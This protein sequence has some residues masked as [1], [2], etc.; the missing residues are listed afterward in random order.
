MQMIC[1]IEDNIKKAATAYLKAFGLKEGDFLTLEAF[2]TVEQSFNEYENDT[3]S[4]YELQTDGV[5][6]KIT[7]PDIVL[8]SYQQQTGN[9]PYVQAN[10]SNYDGLLLANVKD[11]FD[12]Q[13]ETFKRFL[14][15]GLLSVQ[16]ILKIND[17]KIPAGLKTEFIQLRQGILDSRESG[18]FDRAYLAFGQYLLEGDKL[19]TTAL[20]KINEIRSANL[21]DQDRF[22]AINQLVD[23]IAPYRSIVGELFS[24]LEGAPDNMLKNLVTALKTT[25]ATIDAIH[26]KEAEKY[27]IIQ[28]DK[29]LTPSR[30]EYERQFH[31]EIAELQAHAGASTGRIRETL[32]SKI[33]QK[34]DEFRDSN[35]TRG[36]I[37]KVLKGEFGDSSFASKWVGAAITNGDVIVQGFNLALKQAMEGIYNQTNSLRSEFAK[38]YDDF[39]RATGITDFNGQDF[40]KKY[41]REVDV[42][43]YDPK[44]NEVLS[45]KTY[46]ILH[47]HSNERFGVISR[48]KAELEMAEANKNKPEVERLTKLYD[49]Y[50]M[51]N[52]ERP[53]VDE[54]YVADR[55]LDTVVGSHTVRERRARIFDVM[56]QVNLEIKANNGHITQGQIETMDGLWKEYD[57][58]RSKLNTDGTQKTGEDLEVANVLEQYS[59]LRQGIVT[60]EISDYSRI[61]FE[62]QKAEIDAHPDPEV[63]ARWYYYNTKTEYDPRWFAD[64]LKLQTSLGK[65]MDIIARK[66][67]NPANNSQEKYALLETI[68]R[69]YRDNNGTINGRRATIEE[70]ELVKSLEEEIKRIKKFQGLGLTQEQM[71]SLEALQI[72]K[73]EFLDDL[74]SPNDG[75]AQAARKQVALIN[76]QMKDI[77]KDMPDDVKN[78]VDRAIQLIDD[79][80]ALNESSLTD[81][82]KDERRARFAE[83]LNQNP[84]PS[85]F[86]Y[87]GVTFKRA[88]DN[89]L[90][91]FNTTSIEETGEITY[92]D[93][94]YL[95]AHT[96]FQKS[97]EQSFENT[98]WYI[99][100][101]VETWDNTT[102]KM[103]WKP[104]Y[105]WKHTKPNSTYEVNY[106]R[107]NRNWTSSN[108]KKNPRFRETNGTPTPKANALISDE[109]DALSRDERNFI[110]FLTNAYLEAQESY[111]P[112]D[113]LGYSIPRKEKG[114]SILDTVQSGSVKTSAKIIGRRFRATE[115][116]IENEGQFELGDSSGEMVK[117]IPVRFTSK[118]DLDLVDT[119]FFQTFFDYSVK[120]LEYQALESALPLLGATEKVLGI[121]NYAPKSEKYNVLGV[122]FGIH[123]KLRLRGNNERLDTIRQNANMII[124]G[125][126][127]VVAKIGKYKWNKIFNNL[128]AMDAFKILAGSVPNQFVNF[129]GGVIQQLIRTGIE[130]GLAPYTFA[131]WNQA[132]REYEFKYSGQLIGDLS[133][134][135]KSYIGQIFEYFGVFDVETDIRERS[136]LKDMLSTEVLM[137]PRNIVEHSLNATTFLAIANKS[138]IGGLP[139]LEAF[140]LVNGVLTPRFQ[141]TED[142]REAIELIKRKTDALIR[143]VNGNY[144]K[145]DKTLA[146]KYWIGRAV[147]FMKK[148]MVTFVMARWG[149]RR[150]SVEHGR[151]VEGY[152][153]TFTRMAWES[154]GRDLLR[155][156]P[157]TD[158]THLTPEEK[159][160]N[161]QVQ[162]ELLLITMMYAA[163]SLIFGYDDD[164]KER[165]QKLRKNNWVENEM[166]YILLKSRAEAE[167]FV[168]PFGLDD[169]RKQ[170]DGMF[171]ELFPMV[172]NIWKMTV[173]DINYIPPGLERYD[174]KGRG[175]DK[176]D[177]KLVHDLYKLIGVSTPKYDPVGAIQNME[178]LK[179]R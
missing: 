30:K 85:D 171:R 86:E 73:E 8:A 98:E 114:L 41:L 174:K 135:N 15:D 3:V 79:L 152:H 105:I 101:H 70:Q 12:N 100:N 80:R 84:M 66:T 91:Y 146:E 138:Q 44:T 35:P 50:L 163:V 76:K 69:K 96:T 143:D 129:A 45:Y 108:V 172:D 38:A 63:R 33:K 78:L 7:V 19:S 177:I 154:K 164:D 53:Y 58:M 62:K 82:Y 6:I 52:F 24:E 4:I 87:N 127:D 115:Q 128:M 175:Y 126:Q 31:K 139:L 162:I 122:K 59:K 178:M 94:D 40:L 168:V 29:I 93:V 37:E 46:N 123:R 18:D 16:Q 145:L 71:D 131:E 5:L 150:F 137:M 134:I 51:D 167:T 72:R 124:Y 42:F 161:R 153:R 28:Y 155:V 34:Q 99:R 89:G 83:H 23:L 166:L 121:H 17:K 56:K 64:K 158:Q 133:T 81:Y 74:N 157:F 48:F 32:L 14:E 55:L 110:D 65:V 173:R 165:F 39:K 10:N 67:G 120:A 95:T 113:R 57:A 102:K 49:Q 54:F 20:A 11:Q 156:L 118:L 119:N 107:P 147:F 103:E 26:L 151:F 142:N 116:D 75:L 149:E 132:H 21:G 13:W 60:Y 1:G 159:Y 136:L 43:Y 141:M 22:V 160:A 61:H 104:T 179:N 130:G 106:N 144:A 169:I 90:V 2:A 77:R 9:T 148:Y 25:M 170:R 176:G 112:H 36:F 92:G 68:A 47:R 125:E 140:E 27:S 111:R 117:F 88:D 109:Y 97:L